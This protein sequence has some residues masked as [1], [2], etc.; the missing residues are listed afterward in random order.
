MRAAWMIHQGEEINW[1]SA[2][3]LRRLDIAGYLGRAGYL[4]E[5]TVI[6]G[7]QDGSQGSPSEMAERLR[8]YDAV[9]F[10]EQS[11]YDHE[12]M[13]K[14]REGTARP[15]VLRDH[16]EDIWGF[17]WEMECF[18]QADLVVCSSARLATIASG[19]HGLQS[20][21]IHEHYEEVAFTNT[22]P[23]HRRPLVAGYM[24]TDGGLAAQL[25][26]VAASAGWEVRILCRPENGI[27]GSIPWDEH[28]WK[29]YFNDF[30]LLL[31][32]QQ[33]Q[34][35]AKSPCKVIQGL[36]NGMP[37][38]ASAT[39]ESYR[40]FVR[41]GHNGLLLDFDPVQWRKAFTLASSDGVVRHWADNAENSDVRR[42]HSLKTVALQWL[43]LFCR[44]ST[45]V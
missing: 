29:G 14:L 21:V 15:A 3:R 25:R 12:V 2:L 40:D 41:S 24:G 11:G 9:V 34:F 19:T 32:P 5:A 37:V 30:R 23:Y 8:G 39:V 35:T 31:C 6:R 26:A 22:L 44:L 17:P 10:A 16:C 36:G 38:L 4:D 28:S 1:S 45:K 7:Y 43:S 18:R 42:S 33:P 13:C 20:L 27:E